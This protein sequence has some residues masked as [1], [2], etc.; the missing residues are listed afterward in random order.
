MSSPEQR[1]S[2]RVRRHP[3]ATPFWLRV[4]Q[5][6]AYKRASRTAALLDIHK[7]GWA[8]LI[9]PGTLN[10]LTSDRCALAQ[11]YG[12]F[13]VGKKHLGASW[14]F[15]EQI[16]FGVLAGRLSSN[17]FLVDVWTRLANERL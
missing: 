15:S 1:M 6:V 8:A 3:Q 14:S 16:H 9:D 5:Y 11:V 7:P 10:I 17:S 12:Q 13:G 2:A 4:L